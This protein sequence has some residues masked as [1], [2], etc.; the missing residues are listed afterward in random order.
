MVNNSKFVSVGVRSLTEINA[1]RG[2]AVILYGICQLC[3]PESRA[4]SHGRSTW[5]Y[6][7]LFRRYYIV[8]VQPWHLLVSIFMKTRSLVVPPYADLD[9]K[10]LMQASLQ[11]T[12]SFKPAHGWTVTQNAAGTSDPA[13]F[14]HFTVYM[15]I[16]EKKMA[17]CYTWLTKNF[18]KWGDPG[19]FQPGQLWKIYVQFD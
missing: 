9:E 5:I 7:Y 4:K 10:V 6:F 3:W 16:L 15:G 19:R 8:T 2:C 18:V 1:P 12:F 13:A 17:V 14:L 11:H